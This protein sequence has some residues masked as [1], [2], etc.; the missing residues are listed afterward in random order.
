[1]SILIGPNPQCFEGTPFFADVC[2]VTIPGSTTTHISFNV[3][4]ATT[5]KLKKL[6]I[7]TTNDGDFE[8]IAGGSVIGAGRLHN[9]EQNVA[10]KF[11]PPRP[12]TAGTLVEVKFSCDSEPS[13][14]CPIKCFLSASDFIV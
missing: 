8:I 4:P 12:I 6:L 10:F 1:M 2:D 11:D 5:R 14:S 9:T 7:T 3:P 13:I